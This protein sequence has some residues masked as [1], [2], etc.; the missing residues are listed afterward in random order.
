MKCPVCRQDL[1]IVEWNDVEL[2]LCIDGHGIWF[3]ADELQQLF[4]RGDGDMT[5][6][7]SALHAFEQRL[8]QLPAGE[9]PARR[10]PRCDAWM[11]HVAPPVDDDGP[12]PVV[13]DACPHEHGLWFDDGELETVLSSRAVDDIEGLDTVRE[14]LR[15]FNR[16]EFQRASPETDA[17]R[18]QAD[19][20]DET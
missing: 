20:N 11:R 4:A 16:P 18:S 5:A 15:G 17:P 13:L 12:A 3:D 7:S 2:D 8:L 1:V 10:C 9:H 19:R 6:T 14:F